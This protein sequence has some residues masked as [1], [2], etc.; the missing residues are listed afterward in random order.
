M[1][2]VIAG[3]LLPRDLPDLLVRWSP[4]FVAVR[5]A[6]CDGDRTQHVSHSKVVAFKSDLNLARKLATERLARGDSGA[7]K[8]KT[9]KDSSS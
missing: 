4:D 7:S 3:S 8:A 1:R 9:L 5:G 6:V 2:L